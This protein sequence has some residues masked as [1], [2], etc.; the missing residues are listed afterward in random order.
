M[1]TTD[2]GITTFICPRCQQVCTRM[3]HS[4]DFEHKCHGS[5][6]LA[7]E[8][9]LVIGNWTD[10]TGSDSNV[11]PGIMQVAGTDNKLQG[12][13][14]GLEGNR[15]YTR[16]SRGFRAGVYRTRQHIEHL[17]PETFSNEGI[18]DIQPETS[19]KE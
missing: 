13:R 12:T 9:V 8:D 6:V 14:A 11:N 7:N 15:D 4:G 19:D 10:Y 17:G 2:I 5:E 18:P 16:T 3:P 1:N